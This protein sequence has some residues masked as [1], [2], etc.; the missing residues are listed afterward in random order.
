MLS[1]T[2]RRLYK[3]LIPILKVMHGD[4]KIIFS[5]IYEEPGTDMGNFWLLFLEMSDLLVQNIDACHARNADFLI[6]Q[7]ASRTDG[8]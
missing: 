1:V 8:I 4:M 7:H 2:H 6:I 3:K 5:R